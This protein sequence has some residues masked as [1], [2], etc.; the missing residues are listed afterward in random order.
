MRLGT[1]FYLC[2]GGAEVQRFCFHMDRAEWILLHER[3]MK[4]DGCSP[5]ENAHICRKR[6]LLIT[7]SLNEVKTILQSGSLIFI[8]FI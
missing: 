1:D 8:A 6:L 4:G 5:E 7:V 2:G 3:R